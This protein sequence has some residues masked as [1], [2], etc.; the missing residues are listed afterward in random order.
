MIYTTFSPITAYI[1]GFDPYSR[2]HRDVY[3]NPNPFGLFLDLDPTHM[4]LGLPYTLRSLGFDPSLSL[5][6]LYKEPLVHWRGGEDI[7]RLKQ[8]N[9]SPLLPELYAWVCIPLSLWSTVVFFPSLPFASKLAIEVMEDWGGGGSSGG[10][11]FSDSQ[12]CRQRLSLVIS[13]L[14]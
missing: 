1:R 11:S 5:V 7:E 4:T 14:C 13:D 12:T 10:F 8:G 6:K 2:V 3:I 9:Y